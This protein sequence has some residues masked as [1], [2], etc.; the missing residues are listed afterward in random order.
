MFRN[1]RQL[2]ARPLTRHCTAIACAGTTGSAAGVAAVSNLAPDIRLNIELTGTLRE[3]YEHNLLSHSEWNTHPEMPAPCWDV[4]TGD[5]FYA[6][7]EGIG[8]NDENG[9]YLVLWEPCDEPEPIAPDQQQQIGPLTLTAIQLCAGPTEKDRGTLTLLF[10]ER[11]SITL[12][13]EAS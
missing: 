9:W 8:H 6:G 7:C 11:G 10:L 3:S 4:V 12:S 5:A 1:W 13:V 2:F